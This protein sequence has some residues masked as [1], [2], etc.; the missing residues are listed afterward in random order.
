MSDDDAVKRLRSLPARLRAMA[1]EQE[2]RNTSGEMRDYGNSEGLREAAEVVEEA[3]GVPLRCSDCGKVVVLPYVDE[4]HV[5]I[6]PATG[7]TSPPVRCPE[8]SK[9]AEVS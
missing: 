4:E 5:S 1:D 2:Q 3:L 7:W 8:C 9:K 6:E